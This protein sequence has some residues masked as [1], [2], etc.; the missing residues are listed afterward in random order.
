M[1]PTKIQ[2]YIVLVVFSMFTISCTSSTNDVELSQEIT[3]NLSENIEEKTGVETPNE[4]LV[5]NETIDLLYE[6]KALQKAN[7]KHFLNEKYIRFKDLGI[8]EAHPILRFNI[9]SVDYFKIGI[10]ENPFDEEKE[11][12]EYYL[13]HNDWIL[14]REYGGCKDVTKTKKINM[15]NEYYVEGECYV[16]KISHLSSGILIDNIRKV[17]GASEIDIKIDVKLYKLKGNPPEGFEP[18]EPEY[19]YWEECPPKTDSCK[20]TWHYQGIEKLQ[21]KY[22]GMGGYKGYHK[23]RCDSSTIYEG[24][25]IW[26]YCKEKQEICNNYKDDDDDN[27][28][29]CDDSLCID[30]VYCD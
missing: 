14:G 13:L 3:V 20:K 7:G 11:R 6:S 12:D 26:T 2:F 27:F 19:K 24:F 23:Y 4:I 30:D 10:M 16:H 15:R 1:K 25:I 22:E 21:E 5:F 29:D 9:R 17:K 28:M 18:A 8:S